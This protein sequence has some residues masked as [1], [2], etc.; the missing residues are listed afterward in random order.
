MSPIKFNKSNEEYIPVKTA[1]W[2]HYAIDDKE[3]FNQLFN[4]LQG[5]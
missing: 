4:N 2:S 1:T 5:L 3:D